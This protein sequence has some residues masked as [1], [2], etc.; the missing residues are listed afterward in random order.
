M[1][2]IIKPIISEKSI[3]LAGTGT[4]MFEVPNTANKLTVANA[5]HKNFKVDVTAVRISIL[6]GKTKSFKGIKG[7]RSSA[8]RAFVTVKDGQ[9]ISV[10]EENK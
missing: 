9:K 3:M 2:T 7:T 8:K 5:V 6:K 1:Q 10:F 4:Y